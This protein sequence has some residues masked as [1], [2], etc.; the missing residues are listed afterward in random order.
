MATYYLSQFFV[1]V[2]FVAN[3]PSVIGTS[4]VADNV[5]RAIRREGEVGVLA[6]Q[7]LLSIPIEK[8]FTFVI[9]EVSYIMS[10]GFE[11]SL[12]LPY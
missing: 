4:C 1:L 11:S 6:C 10:S 9:T 2:V 3:L 5:L 7:Y 8:Q 12:I